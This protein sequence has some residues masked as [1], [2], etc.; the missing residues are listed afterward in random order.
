MNDPEQIADALKSTPLAAH[1]EALLQLL[2]PSIRIGVLSVE[3]DELPLGASRFGGL[4]DLPHSIAWPHGAVRPLALAAQ[5]R[6]AD[7]IELDA[8]RLLPKS[9]WLY[10][11]IDAADESPFE[12]V[13]ERAPAWQVI[14][15]EGEL[16]QLRRT[17][18]PADTDPRNL[19][20][21]CALGFASEMTLPSYG[22]TQLD[23]LGLTAEMRDQYEGIVFSL[24]QPVPLPKGHAVGTVRRLLG[25][26]Q[27]RWIGDPIHRLLGHPEHFQQDPRLD[28]QRVS[29]NLPLVTSAA[30]ALRD[31]ARDWKLLLQLDAYEGGPNWLWGDNGTMY[32]G[33]KT[34]DLTARRFDQVQWTVECG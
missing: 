24:H 19:F 32:F 9:G 5:L 13:G 22:S 2:E 31:A 26:L 10:F 25:K 14:Y 6:L 4:P 23:A 20:A 28:W 27:H 30:P 16:G 21:T 1:T 11:F 29:E 15:F 18:P 7:L 12:A 17:E 34:T 8:S 33:M 3:A